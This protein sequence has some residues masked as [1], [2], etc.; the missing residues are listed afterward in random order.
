MQ[1]MARVGCTSITIHQYVLLFHSTKI[2][3]ESHLMEH[4]GFGGEGAIGFIG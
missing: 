4:C 1:N 3:F 2:N